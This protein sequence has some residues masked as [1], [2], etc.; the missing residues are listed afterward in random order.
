MSVMATARPTA[1]LGGPFTLRPLPMR[2]PGQRRSA[3]GTLN[4][5][6]TCV[7]MTRATAVALIQSTAPRGQRVRARLIAASANISKIKFWKY[8]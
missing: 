4:T 5:K 8:S 7:V 6:C 1:C 2:S 3:D